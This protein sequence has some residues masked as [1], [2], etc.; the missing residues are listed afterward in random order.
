MRRLNEHNVKPQDCVTIL[1]AKNIIEARIAESVLTTVSG[2]MGDSGGGKDD[3]TF[4]YCYRITD[5]TIQ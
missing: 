5:N 2:F 1:K 4:V 3:S